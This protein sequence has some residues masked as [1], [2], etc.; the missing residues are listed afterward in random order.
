MRLHSKIKYVDERVSQHNMRRTTTYT[1]S[2]MMKD[3]YEVVTLL[4]FNWVSSAN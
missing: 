1:S 2:Y 3:Y 4:K